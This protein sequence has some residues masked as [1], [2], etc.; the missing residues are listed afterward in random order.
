MCA[1]ICFV[2]NLYVLVHMLAEQ[3]HLHEL[4]WLSLSNL[5]YYHEDFVKEINHMIAEQPHLH[6]L[7]WN[8]ISTILICIIMC[9]YI[10]IFIYIQ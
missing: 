8:S 1:F 6:E 4:Q 7:Q 5:R 9:V 10:Y 2:L 3:P